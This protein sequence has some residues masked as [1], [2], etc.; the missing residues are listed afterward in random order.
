MR[1]LGGNYSPFE[2]HFKC[3]ACV[4]NEEHRAF[5]QLRYCSCDSATAILRMAKNSLSKMRS[6][7]VRIVSVAILHFYNRYEDLRQKLFRNI[8]YKRVVAQRFQEPAETDMIS[9]EPV[10]RS[11]RRPQQD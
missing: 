4:L 10:W 2:K 3:H 7:V 1:V 8:V 9:N 6:H 11:P 5:P